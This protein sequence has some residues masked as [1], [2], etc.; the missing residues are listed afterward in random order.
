MPESNL[1]AKDVALAEAYVSLRRDHN[2][3]RIVAGNNVNPS[4]FTLLAILRN[5][6]YFLPAFLAHYR[7]LG[8]ER[9][10]FLNDR[11]DDGSLEY[12]LKQP[13]VTVVQ[14]NRKFGE[15]IDVPKK[16]EGQIN[17]RRIEHYW[18][19]MLHDMFAPD[20]WSI[21]IDL[22]EFVHLPEGMDFQTLASN[23]ERKN[24]RSIAGVMLDTYPMD[25]AAL[26]SQ[27][28]ALYLD[29]DAPW[30]FDGEQHYRLRKGRK[31]K[32]IYA[33]ARARLYRTYGVDKLHPELSSSAKREI[34][35][36]RIFSWLGVRPRR[37]NSTRKQ[38]MIKWHD[39]CYYKS[40]HSTNLQISSDYL[41]P[42]LHFRF[43]GSLYRKIKMA[44]CEGMHYK[45]SVDHH[46]MSQLL[47]NMEKQEG[48]FLYRRSRLF[49]SFS[50]FRI[51][52]NVV[53]L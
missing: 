22:D 31:P 37:Y 10:V 49:R 15:F 51:T 14:S 27:R 40:S 39:R 23:L 38:V 12:V 17:T 11:S 50:D 21:Q 16:I 44:L 41:V 48:S 20:R 9:F 30:Y 36:R 35:L 42:F 8:I 28:N 32:M 3:L 52:R 25:I 5:E 45:N 1:P 4:A 6:V 46:L 2:D 43:S 7:R 53:G 24:I 29:L 33:G 13:D 34:E 18:R 19:A 26:L 47:Q